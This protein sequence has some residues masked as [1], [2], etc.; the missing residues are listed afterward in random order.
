MRPLPFGRA[1]LC[2]AQI[3]LIGTWNAVKQEIAMD[4]ITITARHV[5]L[6]QSVKDYAMEKFSHVDRFFGGVTSLDIIFKQEDRKIHCEVIIHVQKHET[7]VVDVARDE[8]NESID[9]AVDK[10]ERQLRRLKEKISGKRSRNGAL[11][12]V[13]EE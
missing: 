7:I 2:G 5:E 9:V 13:A 11:E 6:A 1:G 12:T 3:V 4:K 10:C 8:F